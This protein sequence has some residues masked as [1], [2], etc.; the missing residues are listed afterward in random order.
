MAIIALK[1]DFHNIL[2][3][4]KLLAV[5]RASIKKSR[6]AQY[7]PANLKT[8][9][10]NISPLNPVYALPDTPTK[11]IEITLSW[12]QIVKVVSLYR[13][14]KDQMDVLEGFLPKATILWL[15][16]A[17]RNSEYAQTLGANGIYYKESRDNFNEQ[18]RMM[19]I[20]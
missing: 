20:S 18:K 5:F 7:L 16:K 3:N 17:I 6:R 13:R 9:G 14:S 1:Q 15:Q 11:K 19:N 4:Y 2:K 10:F 8:Q 12:F